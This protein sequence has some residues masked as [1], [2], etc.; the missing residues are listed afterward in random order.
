MLHH[1]P[2]MCLIFCQ[3][4][5]GLTEADSNLSNNILFAL[6]A[7]FIRRETTNFHSEHMQSK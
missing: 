6:V 1:D 5:N 3:F 2:E 4:D 7:C